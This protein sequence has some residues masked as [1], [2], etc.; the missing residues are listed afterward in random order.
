M[1]Y[2]LI[3]LH[4]LVS[5]LSLIVQPRLISLAYCATI[6]YFL[7]NYATTSHFF[8]LLR[9]HVLFL[10][11]IPQP[12]PIF[13]LI[14][15]PHLISLSYCATASYFFALLRNHFLFFQTF[16]VCAS[17]VEAQ[18]YNTVLVHFP[19]VCYYCGLGEE[20]LVDDD[21]MRKLRTCYAV[22]LPL[23]FLC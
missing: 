17:P 2:F 15:Q 18:Y 22:V 8:I 6:S 4:N 13:Y 3:L 20:S 9:N 21:E 7:S 5:V 1:A 23:C 16:P 14:A 10:C 19:P 12:M 11:L